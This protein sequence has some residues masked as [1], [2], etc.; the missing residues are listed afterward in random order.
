MLLAPSCPPLPDSLRTCP[1]C[2][3][4]TACCDGFL[5]WFLLLFFFSASELEFYPANSFLFLTQKSYWVVVFE[6]FFCF[7]FASQAKSLLGFLVV[8][9]SVSQVTET[10]TVKG[11]LGL[12]L[13]LSAVTESCSSA[14]QC[15]RPI[16]T[17]FRLF[18]CFCFF[19]KIFTSSADTHALSKFL[20]LD[21]QHSVRDRSH[22]PVLQ[23]G[24]LFLTVF[25][26]LTLIHRLD[27]MRVTSETY[28]QTHLFQQCF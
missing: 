2:Q 17:Q 28:T 23:R 16:T 25:A 12:F 1:P 15:H 14:V 6:V 26:I 7:C 8:V 4:V 27:K 19:T 24:M 9:V 5:V 11:S 20:A 13:L 18:E 3:T 22:M 10:L 21:P